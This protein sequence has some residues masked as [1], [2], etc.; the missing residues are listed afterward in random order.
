MLVILVVLV[1]GF[2]W[3][4]NQLN[5]GGDNISS[6]V[7][8]PFDNF[9]GSDTLEYMMA[10]MHDALIGE[11]GKVGSLRVPGTKT[12]NAFRN[13]EK[14]IPEIASELQVDAGVETSVSCF[15]DTICLQVKLVSAFPEEKQIWV[16]DYH[17][18]KK[19]DPKLV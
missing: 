11:V 5:K 19:P 4:K 8:L 18:N 7:F 6:L 16:K 13:V 17:I 9:T 12:A 10:G 14:S 15:G 2:F 3:L 1:T